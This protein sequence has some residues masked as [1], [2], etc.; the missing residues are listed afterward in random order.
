MQ[1][2][3]GTRETSQIKVKVVYTPL[4]ILEQ[5]SRKFYGVYR[6]KTLAYTITTRLL[7]T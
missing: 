1:T 2:I 6:L 4:G 7:S 3:C 5:V